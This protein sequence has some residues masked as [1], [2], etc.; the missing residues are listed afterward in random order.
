MKT[1]LL[2][3]PHGMFSQY[4]KYIFQYVQ[5]AT[6]QSSEQLRSL[7][8]CSFLCNSGGFFSL[9]DYSGSQT[10]AWDHERGHKISLSRVH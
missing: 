3:H 2:K 6:H 4:R 10:G 9:T 7:A 5:Y 1:L 8:L